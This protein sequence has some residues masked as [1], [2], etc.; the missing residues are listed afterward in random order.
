MTK[1]I[2][3]ASKSPR[4]K[5]LLEDSGL[6]FR[7]QC[8]KT[9]EILDT[10]LSLEEAIKKIA[11]KKAKAV[12]IKHAN[13][14]VIGADTMVCLGSEVIGKPK[15]KEDACRIL[16]LLSGK[17]HKVISGVAILSKETEIIFS[18]VTSVTFYEL[19]EHLIQSYVHTLEPYDKAGAYGI[20]GKGKLF[21]KEIQGDYNNV[22]GL[23]IAKVYRE[24]LKLI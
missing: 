13:A 22:V 9:E 11:Y 5:E 24:L 6:S 7:V 20:Q 21:V 10:T 2:I 4:R 14:I 3:L 12:F 18:Q 19:S 23:P 17:T 8:E 16:H 15:D 1:T